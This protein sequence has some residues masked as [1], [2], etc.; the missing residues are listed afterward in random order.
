MAG[1]AAN[2]QPVDL[3]CT[4]RC[5]RAGLVVSAELALEVPWGV[6]CAEIELSGGAVIGNG[7]GKEVRR[8]RGGGYFGLA[9]QAKKRGRRWWQARRREA[10]GVLRRGWQRW[11]VTLRLVEWMQTLAPGES[12]IVRPAR[13]RD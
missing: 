13:A 3:P 1:V 9:H 11:V 5:A 4:W 10:R 2:A 6:C 8:R 12:M 7:V